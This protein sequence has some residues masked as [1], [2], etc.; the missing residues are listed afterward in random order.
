VPVLTGTG[1]RE[2]TPFFYLSI[3]IPVIGEQ[4]FAVGAVRDGQW[5]LV[6][7]QT[8]WYPEILEP[9]AKVGMYGHGRML[10][11]LAADRGEQ[12]DVAAAHP[13]VVARLEGEVAAFTAGAHPA[14]VVP[15]VAAP[16]DHTGWG[17]M[18]R[19]VVAAGLVAAGVALA[20]VLATAWV[21]RR[22]IRARRRSAPG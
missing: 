20:I 14:P 4:G 17:K 13:D 15:V 8:G 19:G 3:R 2:P 22:A 18:W 21:V 10:F 12:H 16:E 1:E 6:L 11:D 7:P 5:K 9:L